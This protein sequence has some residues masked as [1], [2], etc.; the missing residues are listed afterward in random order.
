MAVFRYLFIVLLVLANTVL[1]ADTQIEKEGKEKQKAIEA[2]EARSR[3]G[4]IEFT[5]KQWEEL[6]FVN[7]RPYDVVVLWNVRPGKCEHC[8]EA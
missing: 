6:V 4:I 7:P 3:N 1:A 2:L 5:K 8:Q